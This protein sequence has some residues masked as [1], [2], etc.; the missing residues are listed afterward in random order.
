MVTS[1]IANACVGMQGMTDAIEMVSLA[2]QHVGL[3]E[4]EVAICTTGLIGVELPMA[5][6]RS[7]IPTVELSYSGGTPF[8]KS[9]LTTDTKTKEIAVSVNIDGE[10][11]TIGG[12]AKGVGM[13]EP[14]MATMLA[15]ITTD[16]TIEIET[17]NKLLK[18][19]VNKTFNQISV[20]GDQSTNDTVLFLANGASNSEKIDTKNKNYLVFAEAFDYV[21]EYLAKELVSD[22]EGSN[23]VIECEVIGALSLDDAKLAAKNVVSSSLVKSMVQGLGFMAHLS[24]GIHTVV[25]N[26]N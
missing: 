11:I 6:L 24:N 5:L 26:K 4:K 20:D 14:N 16:A 1:G 19:A 17:Q 25:R 7:T 10:Q 8:A 18:D 21:C 2:S 12:C 15:F 13:I 3:N 23:H 22:G 9:I